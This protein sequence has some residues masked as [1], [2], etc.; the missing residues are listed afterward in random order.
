MGA[1]DQAL[2]MAAVHKHIHKLMDALMPALAPSADS[3][4]SQ[5]MPI[6]FNE[7]GATGRSA[8]WDTNPMRRMPGLPVATQELAAQALDPMQVAPTEA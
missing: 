1:C 7:E 8:T 5:S 4:R 6:H 2:D 3:M